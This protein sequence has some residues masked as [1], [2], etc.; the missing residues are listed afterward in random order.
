[1]STQYRH[2]STFKAHPGKPSKPRSAIKKG[3]RL[4]PVRKVERNSEAWMKQKLTDLFSKFIRTRDPFCYCGA[5]ATENGHY[6]SRAVPSTEYEPDAC[7]G[8]CHDCNQIHESNKEPMK[9]ALIARIGQE[10][11]EELERQSWDHVK[12]TFSE[13][14]DLLEKYK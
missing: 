7:L 12:L 1:M 9:R 11:F 10:R 6:F 5:P 3:K 2:N 13:V 8:S 14:E 4:R